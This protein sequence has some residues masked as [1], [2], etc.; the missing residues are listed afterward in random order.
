MTIPISDFYTVRSQQ[1]SQIK[2][3]QYLQLA[4]DKLR[5]DMNADDQFYAERIKQINQSIKDLNIVK[6]NFIKAKD[7]ISKKL[8]LNRA[9]YNDYIQVD[10][11]VDEVEEQISGNQLEK[12]KL[13][14]FNEIENLFSNEI[15]PSIESCIF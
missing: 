14:M 10:D 7:V 2:S 15:I 5:F 3:S 11:R 8:L 6:S 9:S 4:L 1:V 12:I 13:L